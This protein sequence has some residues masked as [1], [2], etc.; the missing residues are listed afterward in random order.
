ME[1]YLLKVLLLWLLLYYSWLNDPNA[2]LLLNGLT[3]CRWLS[4]QWSLLFTKRIGSVI[5]FIYSYCHFFI[6]VC[7]RIEV[8][9]VNAMQYGRKIFLFYNL[10]FIFELFYT[11]Y[12][13]MAMLMSLVEWR[14][15]VHDMILS[16]GFYIPRHI[17]QWFHEILL[18]FSCEHAVLQRPTSNI[19]GYY[20]LHVYVKH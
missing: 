16:S 8:L 19:Y 11:W 18:I 10:Y 20:H 9:W 7:S 15:L 17:P 4:M 6:I 2:S 1:K 5:V 14:S 12:T 13:T 3:M